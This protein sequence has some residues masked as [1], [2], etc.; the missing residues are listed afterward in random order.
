MIKISEY[1]CP[2]SGELCLRPGEVCKGAQLLSKDGLCGGE[3]DQGVCPIADEELRR[4]AVDLSE[5]KITKEDV[6]IMR[7]D[8]TTVVAVYPKT[9]KIAAV[10]SSGKISTISAAAAEQAQQKAF[11]SA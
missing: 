6:L 9:L 8:K 10:R 2:I 7:V 1:L 3:I 4:V 5:K 11:F